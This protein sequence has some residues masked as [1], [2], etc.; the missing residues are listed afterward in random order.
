MNQRNQQGFS[1]IELLIVVV[2][3]G[4]ITALAVPSLRK[5]VWAAQSGNTVATLRTVSS[6]QAAFYSQRERF[7]RLDEINPLIGNALGSISG[8]QAIR[9]QYVIAMVPS[10]PSD[11]EL[12]SGYTIVATK[13]IPSD[14][15]TYQYEI[16]HTGELRQILP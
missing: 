15:L 2:L 5:G 11:A 12:R 4:I 13:N 3:V 10:V 14:G 16:S 8:N 9:N 6:T 7:G 1:L